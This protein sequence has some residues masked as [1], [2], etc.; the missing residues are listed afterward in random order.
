MRWAQGMDEEIQGWDEEF[1]GSM[2]ASR[3]SEFILSIVA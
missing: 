2:R 3:G 1:W